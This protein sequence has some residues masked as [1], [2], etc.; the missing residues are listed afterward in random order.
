MNWRC[1]LY[2]AN[3][4]D[5]GVVGGKGAN[6]DEWGSNAAGDRQFAYATRILGS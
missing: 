2:T 6:G 5:G 1:R 4:E 3:R